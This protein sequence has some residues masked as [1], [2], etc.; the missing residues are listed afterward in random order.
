MNKNGNLK[1]IL[2]SDSKEESINDAILNN[3]KNLS[4]KLS[5]QFMQINDSS[6]QKNS[7]ININDYNSQFSNYINIQSKVKEKNMNDS[8]KK[9]EKKAMTSF[10]EKNDNIKNDNLLYHQHYKNSSNS[11]EKEIYNFNNKL[12]QDIL[13]KQK[14]S[15][16]NTYKNKETDKIKNKTN[17]KNTNKSEKFNFNQKNDYG[18]I[19]NKYKKKINN[20]S[21]NKME[22]LFSFINNNNFKNKSIINNISNI[23]YMKTN[24]NK[25]NNN[26]KVYNNCNSDIKSNI[27]INKKYE[28]SCPKFNINKNNGQSQNNS[29]IKIL[30]YEQINEENNTENGG[31]L[32]LKKPSIEIFLAWTVISF[33]ELFSIYI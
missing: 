22:K 26:N 21:D 25:E 31:N 12:N 15:N 20:N 3:K 5:E 14:I 17:H 7:A 18:K 24:P 9:Y 30:N 16:F 13:I 32:Y 4:N 2:S 27:P 19:I 11:N 29:N 6:K 8:I 10:E 33:P 23:N 28:K 1:S